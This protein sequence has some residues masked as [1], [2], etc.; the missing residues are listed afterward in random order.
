MD[1]FEVI[2]ISAICFITVVFLI[3]YAFAVESSFGIVLSQ[4]CR[5]ML[6]NNIT[7]D[8]PTYEDINTLFP[9]TSDRKIIGDFGYKDG[10]YQRLSSQ[11]KNAEGYYNSVSSINKDVLFIDPPAKLWA[12]L[13]II[14]IRPSLDQYLL[15]KKNLDQ[16]Y[17]TTKHSLTLGQGRFVDSCHYAYIDGGNWLFLLGDTIQFIGHNCDPEF[18][19]F[20]STTTTYLSK[21]THDITTSYK[22]KLDNWYKESL[23]RCGTKVCFY[24][25]NQSSPP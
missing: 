10:I 11:Y 24:G 25:N 19:N 5:T 9:D 17:D 13:N 6:K 20:N 18:T 8:C 4:G 23:E 14:E 7:T 15:Q 22:Y 12:K 2:G 16:S 21:I 3:E 1:K